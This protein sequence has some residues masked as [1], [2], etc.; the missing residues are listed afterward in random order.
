MEDVINVV[1]N[2]NDL[3]VRKDLR[4]FEQL[5]GVAPQK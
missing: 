3:N 1:E 4:W 2:F 5:F